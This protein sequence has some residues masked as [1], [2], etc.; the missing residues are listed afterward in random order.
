MKVKSYRDLEVW[1]RAIEAAE[2]VYALAR[3]LPPDER[4][5][6]ASQMPRSAVSIASNIAEGFGRDTTRDLLRYLSI[7]RGSLMELET[8]LTIAVR[9][10]LIDRERVVPVWQKLEQTAQML[11]KLMSNLRKRS[12]RTTNHESRVTRRA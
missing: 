3:S 8:Q 11:N 5:G 1:Q 10:G 7:S 6:M 2:N 12:P 9:V 4:F